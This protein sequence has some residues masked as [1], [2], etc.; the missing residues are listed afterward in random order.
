MRLAA[1]TIHTS[2]EVRIGRRARH[3]HFLSNFR[4][5]LMLMTGVERNSRIRLVHKKKNKQKSSVSFPHE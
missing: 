2:I 1:H 5:R 3:Q 4:T